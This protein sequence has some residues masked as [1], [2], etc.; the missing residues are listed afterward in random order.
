MKGG[1]NMTYFVIAVVLIIIAIGCKLLTIVFHVGSFIN[2]KLGEKRANDMLNDATLDIQNQLNKFASETNYYQRQNE[3]IRE[4]AFVE[5]NKKLNKEQKYKDEVSLILSNALVH[6]K[7]TYPFA[8]EYLFDEYA[9]EFFN[10][11][12]SKLNNIEEKIKNSHINQLNKYNN[13]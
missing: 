7:K 6:L 11:D 2:T 13:Q 1:V 12:V 5:A 4:Q 9:K 8:D 3:M 10:Q